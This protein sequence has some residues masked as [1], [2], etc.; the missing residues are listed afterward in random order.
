MIPVFLYNWVNS[1]VLFW[2][3]LHNLFSHSFLTEWFQQSLILGK[4]NYC[5]DDVIFLASMS[6]TTR[7]RRVRQRMRWL[8]GVTNSMDMNLS[9]LWETVKDT[10]AWCA[11]VHGVA[12]SQTWLSNWTIANVNPL[13]S[14]IK[15]N[16][17]VFFSV[18]GLLPFT[19]AVFLLMLN[20]FHIWP[21]R[22]SWAWFPG[23]LDRSPSSLWEISWFLG[24]PCIFPARGLCSSI[25]PPSIIR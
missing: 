23:L 1:E 12:K 11:A 17:P 2:E 8:D 5:I 6:I 9:K 24:L 18:E 22:A 21:V 7:S 13:F 10:K 4:V 16:P 3:Y 15:I 14:V 19:T 25:F 20:L